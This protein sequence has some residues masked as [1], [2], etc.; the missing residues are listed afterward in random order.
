MSLKVKEGGEKSEIEGDV[1]TKEGLERCH[2]AGLEDG[3]GEP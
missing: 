1:T 3:G 2:I